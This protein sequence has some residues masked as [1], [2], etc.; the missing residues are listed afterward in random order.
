M[1][2]ARRSRFGAA[3]A[4][5]VAAVVVAVA[6]VAVVLAVAVVAVVVVAVVAAAVV[7]A[8]FVDGGAGV[9]GARLERARPSARSRRVARS[10]AA[11]HSGKKRNKNSGDEKTTSAP[12]T[13][14]RRRHDVDA[15]E[16]T[17][18]FAVL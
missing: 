6:V 8:A 13:C 9:S 1:F 16:H 17:R 18:V 5:V 7:V 15:T 12:L 2:A 14:D 10:T 3:V 11:K 4:A